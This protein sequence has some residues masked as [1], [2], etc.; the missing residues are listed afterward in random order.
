[1]EKG[2]PGNLVLKGER[3]VVYNTG[4]QRTD[5]S[6]KVGKLNVHR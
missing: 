6:F 5:I 4:R 3:T 1:M 2:L